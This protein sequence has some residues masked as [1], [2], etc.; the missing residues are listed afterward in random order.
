MSPMQISFSDFLRVSGSSGVGEV[1]HSSRLLCSESRAPRMP[2]DALCKIMA[3][4]TVYSVDDDIQLGRDRCVFAWPWSRDHCRSFT[5]LLFVEPPRGR[6]QSVS[7][8]TESRVNSSDINNFISGR[9]ES[10]TP[11]SSG[12]LVRHSS[13]T[14]GPKSHRFLLIP[15]ST[16]I[17]T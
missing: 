6:F 7:E 3:E 2:L 16:L 8:L 4:A 1:G 13:S 5:S 12:L 11:S 14:E 17:T 15:E 10:W 9:T